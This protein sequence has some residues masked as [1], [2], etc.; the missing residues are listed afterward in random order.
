MARVIFDRVTKVFGEVVALD[1]MEL[2]VHDREFMVV[3]GPS[4]CGKSTALRLVAGLEQPTAG[5]IYIGNRLVDELAPKDRDVAM[6][7]Q[8]YA[9]YPHMTAFDNI[10][11]PLKLR[12]SA[13]GRDRA[14]GST[15]GAYVGS[16]RSSLAQTERAIRRTAAKD[17]LREGDR[18]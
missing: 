13:K 4:G 1:D 7:F 6:V 14:E 18:A 11:H 3:V 5:H 17:R 9:L 8:S 2:E 15:S 10:S 12:G 16:G